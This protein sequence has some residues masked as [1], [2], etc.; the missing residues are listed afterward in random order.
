MISGAGIAGPMLA[1]WLRAAG[2]APTQV[3]HAPQLRRAGY[4]I[5]FWGLGYDLAERMGLLP[6][7]ERVGYHVREVR[8]VDAHGRR[9]TGFGTDVFDRLTGGRFITVRRSDLSRLLFEK[10]KAETETI[11]GDE[12]VG[13]EDDGSG[14]A[15]RFR[16]ASPRRFGLVI[17]A[18]GLHS[19]VRRLAFGPQ[20]QFEKH[21][22]YAVAAFEVNGYRPR[23][24]DVYL[25]YTQ[26]GRMIARFT[27][28]DD[29]T[30]FLFVFTTGDGELPQSLAGQKASLRARYAGA[31]W[32]CP[33]ILDAL[34][35]TDELYF[36]R[37][38]QIRMDR[39]SKGRVALSGD[40]AF[41]VSLLAGQGSALAMVSS[42][43]LAG[44]LAAADG[45][46]AQ[47]FQNYEKRLRDY[48]ATKQQGA[49][50]FAGALAP[51]TQRGLWFR[52]AVI[53]A[54]GVPG[55]AHFAI[56]REITDSLA[57]PDY[58]WPEPYT[59]AA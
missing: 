54:L 47:A 1:Y 18:D 27:L 36:D 11:F 7:I 9:V 59:R 14:V 38:S 32:E 13:L 53:A 24:D 12:I 17:G 33:R 16:D 52:N 45:D 19:G 40:A 51:R 30:L 25:M 55:V 5:D 8:I 35:G 22:G 46:H 43:I 15:V 58:R 37:V 50:R 29:R 26:P 21:L 39:W 56:G 41:C 34:D 4:V 57:L 28:H 10:G 6:A 2:Y 20:Q 3:E 42:Y 44:E 23:D 31:G 48:I 49:V